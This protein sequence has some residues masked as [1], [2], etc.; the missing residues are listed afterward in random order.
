MTTWSPPPSAILYGALWLALALTFLFWGGIAR[1][2]LLFSPSSSTS[3]PTLPV[4]PTLFL[5]GISALSL[6]ALLTPTLLPAG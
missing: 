6:T 4:P 1:L 5:F 3:F 2:Q